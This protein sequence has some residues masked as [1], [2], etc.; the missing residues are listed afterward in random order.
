MHSFGWR[1]AEQRHDKSADA[2]IGKQIDMGAYHSVS[3][4]YTR[5]L[6]NRK[7]ANKPEAAKA[8]KQARKS[9]TPSSDCCPT[10]VDRRRLDINEK[11]SGNEL[12]ILIEQ[13]DVFIHPESKIKQH[14]KFLAD[15]LYFKKR[16]T[17]NIEADQDCENV[18]QA[19]ESN[20]NEISG[21]RNETIANTE[22]QSANEPK[23]MYKI[24]ITT[25]S[26]DQ[27]SNQLRLTSPKIIVPSSDTSLV[28]TQI[29]K[30]A[31]LSEPLE[32][33]ILASTQ[34]SCSTLKAK[35]S[36]TVVNLNASTVDTGSQPHDRLL[37]T[38][39]TTTSRAT[40][41]TL[42]TTLAGT[43]APLIKANNKAF[44]VEYEDSSKSKPEGE[45]NQRVAVK[46]DAKV[47]AISIENP[48]KSPKPTLN[49]DQ[50]LTPLLSNK[51]QIAAN[52]S[53]S[54]SESESESKSAGLKVCNQGNDNINSGEFN[55]DSNPSNP[56]Q[57]GDQ[58]STSS[59]QLTCKLNVGDGIKITSASIR[60]LETGTDPITSSI[61]TRDETTESITIPIN[62]KPQPT[63]S[64]ASKRRNFL[65][66]SP[67]IHHDSQ[68]SDHIEAQL[69]PSRELENED[70]VLEYS[71]ILTSVKSY[72][73]TFQE[74]F[75]S[76]RS[77]SG[78]CDLM[79][80]ITVAGNS[81]GPIMATISAIATS[82]SSTSSALASATSTASTSSTIIKSN[83]IVIANATT[84]KIGPTSLATSSMAPMI[85][86]GSPVIGSAKVE[87]ESPKKSIFDGASK[88]E[89]L[90]YLEDARERVPEILMAADDV[91]V[92]NE[93]EVIVVNQL[94]PEA[95]ATPI[96]IVAA[97]EVIETAAGQSNL[98][99]EKRCT[100]LGCNASA[101]SSNLSSN[102][103]TDQQLHKRQIFY[104]QQ[105]SS[106][107][108]TDANTI[109][110]DTG[111]SGVSGNEESYD[112]QG[113]C[114]SNRNSASFSP[115]NMMDEPGNTVGRI[116]I[117]H[118]LENT[119]EALDKFTLETLTLDPRF[120]PNTICD[121]TTSS[122][123]EQRDVSPLERTRPQPDHIESP[124]ATLCAS[125]GQNSTDLTRPRCNS[126]CETQTSDLSEARYKCDQR[127]VCRIRK[128]NLIRENRYLANRDS[129]SSA[130]S[131]SPSSSSASPS[132][133]ESSNSSSGQT[134]G[135]CSVT[136]TFYA[137][138]SLS[139]SSPL[140]MTS[141]VATAAN[142]TNPTNSMTYSKGY[143]T[144]T[145]L[146]QHN[147]RES[148]AGQNLNSSAEIDP[149][150]SKP[151]Y[152]GVGVVVDTSRRELYE[153]PYNGY[154]NL[155]PISN[156][157]LL[158]QI[159]YCSESGG[160]CIAYQSMNLE[161]KNDVT[162]DEKL[163]TNPTN[164]IDTNSRLDYSVC[165]IQ[166]QTLEQQQQNT[167]L[168]TDIKTV[169][170]KDRPAANVINPISLNKTGNQKP[171]NRMLSRSSLCHNYS[172]LNRLN[173]YLM[174]IGQEA[175]RLES[176]VEASDELAKIDFQC[177]DCDQFLDIDKATMLNKT[178]ERFR[179][180]NMIYCNQNSQ[181]NTAAAAAAAAD[182]DN[183]PQAT[184][185]ITL[186]NSKNQPISAD[187]LDR[188]YI[189]AINGLPLCKSCEKKRSERKEIISEFVETELKYGRD[190]RII[191]DEFLRPM[192]IA[193]L[194][195][196]DQISG[197]FLNLDELI[198]ANGRFYSRLE[199]A[200]N[201]AQSLGDTDF[202]TVNIGKL[203]VESAEM[204][205]S[206]ESYCIRQGLAACL[207]ARL[208]K[209]KELLRIFLRVSQMENTQL[210][211]MNL[212]AFLMVP[213]QRITRYPL[214][215]NRLYKVTAYHHKDRETLRDAQLRV[216]LH[217]EHINQQ[218]KG[219]GAT[220][221]I[222]RRISNL[223]T[224]VTH[225][226]GLI[227]AEDI[228]TMKLRK[229]ALELLQWDRDETQF[230]HSGKLHF[231]P[232][233][234]FMVKQKVKSL[235]FTMAHALLVVLGRP[236]WK[237]QPELVKS[238][239]DN[240][241]MTPTPGGTGIQEAALVLFREKNNRFVLC[242]EPLM[243]K[244]CVLS[245]DCSQ[246][247]SE[248]CPLIQQVSCHNKSGC[249]VSSNSSSNQNGANR[250]KKT[251]IQ[252]NDPPSLIDIR[253]ASVESQDYDSG[254][255]KSS[256]A[257]SSNTSQYGI[258]KRAGSTGSGCASST[259]RRISPEIEL[260]TS[261]SLTSRRN[262]PSLGLQPSDRSSLSSGLD[263]GTRT[264]KGEPQAT[265]LY[266][267]GNSTILNQLKTKINSYSRQASHGNS[268]TPDILEGRM[269][270]TSLS[271]C[272]KSNAIES[273]GNS[274]QSGQ[275]NCSN[276]G[277]SIVL[278]GSS[279][280]T[281]NRDSTNS[282]Q[283][284]HHYINTHHQ[285]YGDYEES[286]E[287]HER[288]TK[289]SLLIRADTTLKTRYWLQMLRYHAKDLGQWRQRRHG[290]SNIMVMRQ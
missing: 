45:H 37:A 217:L 191:H 257:A 240:R 76:S 186:R 12:E 176:G 81:S 27:K 280:S 96:S 160:Q 17:D 192:Q 203:F 97:T 77:L 246:C 127:S 180:A 233:N 255:S 286:F 184:A 237:Y 262:S 228:G 209:E 277:Q 156:D 72:I 242:H 89:I 41:A 197:V 83:D 64:L 172:T 108:T 19:N 211:R 118:P 53:V 235:R 59:K 112:D 158:A 8:T 56:R 102:V 144:E 92:L 239:L 205:H 5:S 193:G 65:I 25:A 103:G 124:A 94:D 43:T 52:A 48:V 269:R 273:S 159:N 142:P 38:T 101:T 126:L 3:S 232:L 267:S 113:S 139:C 238:N 171:N 13:S 183:Q 215:L 140:L 210:R 271:S 148:R 214:L 120:E 51:P 46:V 263:S 181:A 79:L 230:I 7:S 66:N 34:Y 67:A 278:V 23:D 198:L 106:E 10:N 85:D 40:S 149:V 116:L 130:S 150:H 227:N 236:N 129:L 199:A 157:P 283:Y 4:S 195:N 206:F 114:M 284:S 274:S 167:I 31:K 264:S 204:L 145:P 98:D 260:S 189:A 229:T 226:R 78:R 154:I 177:P 287:L 141:A 73:D 1:Q 138:S 216:E 147:E 69:E 131:S 136:S 121:F 30:D 244:N 225:R 70:Y 248:T 165:P 87:N 49:L 9:W 104:Q 11:M 57:F 75:K 182:L 270:K 207:L 187:Q 123:N 253:S 35:P 168:P 128:L 54:G 185:G 151:A 122:L 268:R 29:S 20:S 44:L 251:N 42:S 247:N 223:S 288:L 71:P 221:K 63:R 134:S 200:I 250:A 155:A 222:W 285:P 194:L 243:L 153:N 2:R 16:P 143:F 95:P 188:A 14:E 163:A 289:E 100:G 26:I 254:S 190:L 201:E 212:A 86:V 178:N 50:I 93:N 74:E 107:V 259:S 60:L 170:S 169:G 162:C 90:E 258:T 241:L 152:G 33:S 265:N 173:Y 32:P 196:K 290:L 21:G 111:I 39:S 224:P 218:T 202:N 22:H 213:V 105:H 91:M 279:S 261:R 119:L 6:R 109:D 47:T 249:S 36:R 68:Q 18:G 161:P 82:T 117:E 234:E 55:R 115:T 110:E 137:S 208:A 88:D 132:S 84:P 58:D 252:A 174:N 275:N 272:D 164:N 266:S 281:S 175:G 245:N 61:A 179:L 15:C 256:L 99:D 219:V 282:I 220:N 146:N 166:A 28:A 135:N 24:S 125:V 80:P 62:S 133:N 276:N 231:A